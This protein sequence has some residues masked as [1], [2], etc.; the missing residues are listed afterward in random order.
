MS[1]IQSEIFRDAKKQ[2]KKTHNENNQSITD[3]DMLGR[4]QLADKDIKTAIFNCILYV[5]KL[6][7]NYGRYKKTQIKFLR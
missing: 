6:I 3:P 1:G 5:Q 4:L 2:E 7:R